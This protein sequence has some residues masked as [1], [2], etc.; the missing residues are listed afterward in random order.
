MAPRIQIATLPV[1]FATGLVIM[2]AVYSKYSVVRDY[3]Y[4]VRHGRC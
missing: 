2:A 4:G 1:L 3:C